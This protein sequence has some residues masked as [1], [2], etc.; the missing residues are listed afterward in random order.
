VPDETDMQVFQKGYE[1]GDRVLREAM[2]VV[3]SGG[4]T[5]V[6]EE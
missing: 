2:V 6:P 1:M 5:R 3:S 4:P